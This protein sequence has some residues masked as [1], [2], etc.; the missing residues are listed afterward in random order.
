MTFHAIPQANP[1]IIILQG[2]FLQLITQ[3]EIAILVGMNGYFIPQR[4]K[5][6]LGVQLYTKIIK[7]T[8]V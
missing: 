7:A 8:R 6:I 5:F 3:K 2:G 4:L 1:F